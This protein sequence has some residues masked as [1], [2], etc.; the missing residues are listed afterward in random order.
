MQ[1]QYNSPSIAALIKEFT[2][3]MGSLVDEEPGALWGE[4]QLSPVLWEKFK[5]SE[6]EAIIAQGLSRR[7]DVPK[8]RR[9]K[10]TAGR[11]RLIVTKTSRPRCPDF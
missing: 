9:S 8:I 1:E 10:C 7:E 6:E 3:L 4:L 2:E 11:F 5:R